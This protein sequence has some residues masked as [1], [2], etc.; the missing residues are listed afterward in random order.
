[1][2]SYEWKITKL[3]YMP[4]RE[5]LSQVVTKIHWILVG[6]DGMYGWSYNGIETLDISNIDPNTFVAYD[7]LSKETV[8]GWLET[9]MGLERVNGLKQSIRDKLDQ[10]MAPVLIA[11]DP[12][13]DK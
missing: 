8:I 3:E 7:N 11:A 1:M 12:P 2:T 6:T 10:I 9:N 13:W 4:Q 5:G